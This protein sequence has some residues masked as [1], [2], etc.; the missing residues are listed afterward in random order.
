MKEAKL[1]STLADE[2]ESHK[3]ERLPICVRFI[4]K[5]SNIHKEFSEFC[6]CE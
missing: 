4:N 3:S 2:V 5:N 1:S 6:R